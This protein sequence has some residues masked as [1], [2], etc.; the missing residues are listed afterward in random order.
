MR[1]RLAL[2]VLLAAEAVAVWIVAS[3]PPA[4]GAVEWGDPL[5][6]LQVTD[7]ETATLVVGRW[8]VLVVAGWLLS[9]TLLALG[10]AAVAA[11]P[12]A[13]RRIRR[14]G[15]RLTRCAPAAVVHLVEAALA[16]GVV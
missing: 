2:I 7:P 10:G 8:L 9:S 1:A 4:S 5:R 13:P 11:L 16:V 12:H 15:T 3:H 14:V 6:W